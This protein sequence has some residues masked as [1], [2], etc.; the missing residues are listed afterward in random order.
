M[1]IYEKISIL[2]WNLETNDNFICFINFIPFLLN[3]Q[4]KKLK[5]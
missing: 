2:E 4:K 5:K 3:S 1:K